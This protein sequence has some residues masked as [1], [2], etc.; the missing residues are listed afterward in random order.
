LDAEPFANKIDRAI[1]L[2]NGDPLR[3][4]VKKGVAVGIGPVRDQTGGDSVPQGCPTCT[5]PFNVQGGRDT[6]SD[7]YGKS[8]LYEISRLV[9]KGDNYR[10]LGSWRTVKKVGETR[11]DVDHAG[12]LGEEG[13]LSIEQRLGEVDPYGRPPPHPVI[14]QDH[15]P[16]LIRLDAVIASSEEL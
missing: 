15:N 7:Q 1:K 16:P 4:P 14:P 5:R 6:V 10:V 12:P 13:Y 8:H 3:D 11:V 9:V 2:V